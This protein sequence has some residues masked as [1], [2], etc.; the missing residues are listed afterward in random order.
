[1]SLLEVGFRE[2]VV[3]DVFVWAQQDEDI[4]YVIDWAFNEGPVH[5]P[6]TRILGNP[7]FKLIKIAIKYWEES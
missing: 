3:Q 4:E 6:D 1:M 7:K 2:I 5:G